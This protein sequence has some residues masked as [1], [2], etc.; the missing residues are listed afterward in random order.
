MKRT[1][2]RRKTPLRARTPL[3]RSK[4]LRQRS[5]KRR[6]PSQGD[7][8]RMAWIRSLPCCAPMPHLCRGRID[9]HHAGVKPGLGMKAP[10]DTCIPMCRRSHR[11]FEDHAGQFKGWSPER[12]REW[13]DGQVL[14]YQAI[15]GIILRHREPCQLNRE[16]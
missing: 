6:R 5:P 14:I 11:D 10:D 7:C 3:R 8:E 1:A 15:W 9:P 2:L 16:S 4:P 12:R 13:Q